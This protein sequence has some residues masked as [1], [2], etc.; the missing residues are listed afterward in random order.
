MTD[1]KICPIMS[2]P[3][4]AFRRNGV[5]EVPDTTQHFTPI[6][7]QREKCMAWQNGICRIIYP[8]VQGRQDI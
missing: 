1:E 5:Y 6:Q 3:I 2:R 8:Q 4:V 7:C